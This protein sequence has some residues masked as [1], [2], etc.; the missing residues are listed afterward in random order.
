MERTIEK[1]DAVIVQP[2]D[3]LETGTA[4]RIDTR[5]GNPILNIQDRTLS[6]DRVAAANFAAKRDFGESGK[7]VNGPSGYYNCA[8]LVLASRRSQVGL[9]DLNVVWKILLD[10][11]YV[12]IH[13]EADAEVGDIVTYSFGD[14]CEHIAIVVEAAVSNLFKV[15]RIL[16]KHG[17]SV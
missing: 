1:I 3:P 16:S 8:G 9:H 4:I 15:P 12:T 6:A 5:C 2:G 11:G 14:K 10:D 17:F 7:I 13:Q